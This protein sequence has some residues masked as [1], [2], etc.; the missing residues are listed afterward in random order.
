MGWSCNGLTKH[1]ACSWYLF[2]TWHS[3]GT[4]WYDTVSTGS[5]SKWLKSKLA[6]HSFEQTGHWQP[7]QQSLMLKYV[8]WVHISVQT[9]HAL[10]NQWIIHMHT[11]VG[12]GALW[13]GASKRDN[14]RKGAADVQHC[15]HVF[16]AMSMH[17]LSTR[18]HLV[19]HVWQILAKR[20][21]WSALLT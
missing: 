13:N 20:C 11:Y 9:G 3:L 8:Q 4:A 5:G 6:F 12:L 15:R 21:F 17:V 2:M 7:M 14:S 1:C 10:A 16:A 19:M 18:A